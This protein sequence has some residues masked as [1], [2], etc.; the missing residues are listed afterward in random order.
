M[1]TAKPPRESVTKKGSHPVLASSGAV[2]DVGVVVDDTPAGGTKLVVVLA[3][4]AVVVVVRLGRVVGVVGGVVVDVGAVVVV[5]ATVVVVRRSRVVVVVCSV[6]VV[7]VDPGTSCAPA[8]S[9][10]VRSIVANPMAATAAPTATR[11]RLRTR[12]IVAG[13]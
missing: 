5:G 9:E 1:A 3:G 7:V 11:I 6:V 10:D 8:M 13:S 12:D 2:A 4:L